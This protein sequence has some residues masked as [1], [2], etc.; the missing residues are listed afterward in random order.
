VARRLLK[1]KSIKG[2]FF[3]GSKEV[4]KKILDVTHHDLSKLVALELGG[5]NTTIVHHDA[6]LDHALLELLKACFL[7]SGQRCTS[8]SIVAIHRS[9]HESFIARF[10]ELAKK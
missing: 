5:K 3:T 10:H 7:T 9:I 2:V 8:T 6:N 4:G 1:E